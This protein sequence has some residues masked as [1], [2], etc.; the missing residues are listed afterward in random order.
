MN[1]ALSD[2]T[3]RQGRLESLARPFGCSSE[4]GEQI[5]EANRS[6]YTSDA[7]LT[8]QQEVLKEKL[9]RLDSAFKDFTTAFPPQPNN[10]DDCSQASDDDMPN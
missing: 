4:A 7:V 8:V 10:E 9:T 3:T 2:L 6:T 1:T 5:E